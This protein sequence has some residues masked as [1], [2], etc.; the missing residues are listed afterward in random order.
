MEAPVPPSCPE[1]DRA[2]SNPTV[3]SLGGRGHLARETG[4]LE[5][6]KGQSRRTRLGWKRERRS[7]EETRWGQLLRFCGKTNFTSLLCETTTEQRRTKCVCNQAKCPLLAARGIAKSVHTD[8]FESSTTPK[9]K[10]PGRFTSISYTEK[11][12]YFDSLNTQPKLTIKRF[13]LLPTHRG[14]IP[15]DV[16]CIPK[17]NLQPGLCLMHGCGCMCGE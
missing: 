11:F 3:L 15:L 1:D 9:E 16:F 2:K 4:K 8:G 5:A 13:L 14:H 6:Q 7:E 10:H 17:P 12:L